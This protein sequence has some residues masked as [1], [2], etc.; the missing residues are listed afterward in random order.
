MWSFSDTEIL[1]HADATQSDQIR[2]TISSGTIVDLIDV[3]GDGLLDRVVV[4]NGTGWYVQYNT[5]RDF[6]PLAAMGN[7]TTYPFTSQV[8]DGLIDMNRDG[9]PDA[10]SGSYCGTTSPNYLEIFFGTA[11]PDAPF[12]ASFGHGACIPVPP[13]FLTHNTIKS[14]GVNQGMVDM[15][16]DGI[17]DHFQGDSDQFGNQWIFQRGQH[18]VRRSDILTSVTGATG[19]T[20]QLTWAPSTD[21]GVTP[22]SPRVLDVVSSITTTGPAIT[23]VSMT[24]IYGTPLL[25][26]AWDDPTGSLIEPLGFSDRYELA[27][28]VMTHYRFGDQHFTAGVPV[29]VETASMASPNGTYYNTVPQGT[30]FASTSTTWQTSPLGVASYPAYRALYVQVRSRTEGATTLSSTLSN[31]APDAFGNIGESVYIPDDSAGGVAITTKRVYPTTTSPPKCVA[32][33]LEE[34]ANTSTT[35]PDLFHRYYHYD[36]PGRADLHGATDARDGHLSWVELLVA[37]TGSG[38][39]YEVPTVTTYNADGSVA[40]V[41]ATYTGQGIGSLTTSFTYNDFLEPSLVSVSDGTLT[42]NTGYQYNGYGDV[43]EKDGPYLGTPTSHTGVAMS[44]DDLGRVIL[45]TRLAIGAP[46]GSSGSPVATFEYAAATA[47][48]PAV[49]KTYSF[50]ESATSTFSYAGIPTNDDAVQ[51]IDYF[52][53]F[54]RLVQS[55]RRLGSGTAGT[56][57]N[58]IR[59]LP[60]QYRVERNVI[61]DALGR[62]TAALDPYFSSN[63]GY[64]DPRTSTE[65][66]TPGLHATSVAY[67][68]LSRPTCVL[69]A[70]VNG[71]IASAAGCPSSGAEDSTYRRSTASA[72]GVDSTIDGR[73]YFTEDVTPDW[74]AGT[75][76]KYFDAAGRLVWTRS[77]N[78]T[79]E[80]VQFDALGR[81]SAVIRH[82]GSPT[83]TPI[84]QSVWDY[85]LRG[86]L[87][88]EFADASGHRYYSYAPT[89]ELLVDIRN[90]TNTTQDM[91]AEWTVRTIGSLGRLSHVEHHKWVKSGSCTWAEAPVDKTDFQYDTPYKDQEPGRYGS[92]DELG[93]RLTAMSGSA[94][95]IAFGYDQFGT[96]VLRDEWTGEPGVRNTVAI[97]YGAD[98]RL[99]QKTM[100]SP[101]LAS[102][103]SYNVNYDSVGQPVQAVDAASGLV[104]WNAGTGNAS[105]DPG[106]G[107]YDALS[108]LAAERW[109]GGAISKSRTFLPGSN[110][111]GSSI[112]TTASTTVY[113]LQ[114]LSWK[115]SLLSG[116]TGTSA[117]EGASTSYT[118]AYD[119]DGHLQSASAAPFGAVGPASQQYNESYA[120]SLENLQSVSATNNLGLVS[121]STYAYNDATSR[122]RVT[123]VTL[124]STALGDFFDYD[125]RGR[126]LVTNHRIT[127]TQAPAQDSYEY[128]VPGRL[129]SISHLGAKLE[130]I[131]YD[132][133]GNIVSRTFTNGTDTARY[134]VGDDLTLVRRG[135]TTIGYAHLQVGGGRLASI[136]SKTVGSTTTQGV[137]YY[138]RNLQGSVVA[139]TLGGGQT[140]ISYRYL[141]YGAVD[142]VVGGEVDE[143]ASEL[144][145]IGGLKL[146]GGLIH[147]RARVYSPV[148]RRFLQPDTI[149][150]A[151]YT[152]ASGDPVNFIDPSGRDDCAG[153]EKG[154]CLVNK[155][156][157]NGSPPPPPPPPP[158]DISSFFSW[159]TGAGTEVSFGQMLQSQ[160]IES[161]SLGSPGPGM[162]SFGM[163]SPG[164]FSS[165]GA[166]LDSPL[167]GGAGG[168]FFRGGPYISPAPPGHASPSGNHSPLAA[169]IGPGTAV[170][171]R[172]MLQQALAGEGNAFAGPGTATVFENAASAAAR[173][174]LLGAPELLQK[175]QTFSR[176]LSEF[177]E[178]TTTSIHFVRNIITNAVGDIKIVVDGAGQRLM[179]V[180][181]PNGVQSLIEFI[182]STTGTMTTFV[183]LPYPGAA[184][185]PGSDV[186]CSD[187]QCSL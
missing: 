169:G 56:Q 16:G 78:G 49:R 68:P 128:D 76:R 167:A 23:P 64:V 63:A 105:T 164:T 85:D 175:A 156:G 58:V 50:I 89:G 25:T 17:L 33:V 53:A 15:D 81:V 100:A 74:G 65:L 54:G 185:V 45:V 91:N 141:P 103:V 44:Y 142:K 29:L 41:V 92:S 158:A 24:F 145:F 129:I 31:A 19:S 150:L 155:G 120:F 51:T 73:P 176:A 71:A 80:N 165:I 94:A 27:S 166:L 21:F 61:L 10:V 182:G 118:A 95:T 13:G 143:N 59:N 119:L 35:G 112:A 127:A 109:D 178:G 173:E 136:W 77:P 172:M 30:V 34:Y 114:S 183:I 160:P 148:L 48:A 96:N 153:H 152:Y 39:T 9:R 171:L 11:N 18:Q 36:D 154:T 181:L 83:A 115:G 20:T 138:H 97:S 187:P 6:R 104:Y 28:G 32:C 110:L 99:L 162:E 79:F 163:S 98:G 40:S 159:L 135:T 147:L 90:A 149:D 52:D 60:A 84:V 37:G 146:S 26:S 8:L 132:P 2:T 75:F 184:N 55:R 4:G 125:R 102:P 46:A 186:R 67:D 139:T 57:G 177:G 157:G 88:H 170:T 1:F 131:A 101:Y 168:S 179:Q 86:R 14:G 66:S 5:G 174:P 87:S 106:S 47:T 116:Y 134:Y 124:P 42:L 62:V 117:W 12:L 122:E 69:Y 93:G 7:P 43:I 126:G 144:G 151:R 133:A 130:D 3:N 82:S 161:I 72:Y 123:S 140:G 113:A 107:P 121:T 111:L 108:R 180:R 137:I 22:G 38:G 70:P